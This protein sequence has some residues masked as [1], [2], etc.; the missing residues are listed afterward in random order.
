MKCS[1]P[2]CNDEA[3]RQHGNAN[4]CE[5]HSRIQM[6]RANAQTQGKYKPTIEEMEALIPEVMC[7][8]VCNLE[9]QWAADDRKQSVSLQH[10]ANGTISLVCLS[11]N[12]RM[13]FTEDIPPE[14]HRRCHVC[15]ETKPEEQFSQR[16]SGKPHSACKLCSALKTREYRAR[17]SLAG[18]Q[19]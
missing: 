19:S 11:C 1:R 17:R 2:A 10:W 16:E 4:Y 8:P 18:E 5:V 7:C 15:K 14:G 12:S 3:V 13:T 9:M 6:M